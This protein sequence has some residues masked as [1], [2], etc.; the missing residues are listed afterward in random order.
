MRIDTLIQAVLD[1]VVEAAGDERILLTV[2][3]PPLLASA[4]V[5]TS[6]CVLTQEFV[7]NSFKH[8][9]GEDE[10]GRV[11][12]R[13]TRKGENGAEL[14]VE[15]DGIGLGEIVTVDGEGDGAAHPSEGLGTKIAALLTR[16][17]AGTISYE[18]METDADKPGTRVIVMLTDL[19]LSD[20]DDLTSASADQEISPPV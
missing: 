3:V 6:L 16:Q 13:L 14:I 11:N 12:V 7:V 4:Q 5:A 10:A 15:D 1:D 20:P 19:V 17:F 9:F 18:P 8:A 2:D